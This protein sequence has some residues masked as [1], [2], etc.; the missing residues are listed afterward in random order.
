M[1]CLTGC[2][3]CCRKPDI[4]ATPLEFLPLA[5]ALWS[6]GKALAFYEE[7]TASKENTICTLF[8]PLHESSTGGMCR[9]YTSRG[10]ICR[11]FGFT[12]ARDRNGNAQLVTCRPIKTEQPE[13]YS[14]GLELT[15]KGH[16]AF[17]RDYY[18]RLSCIDP[19]LGRQML[20]VN[21][22]IRVALETVLSY[23]AYR[24]PRRT[25]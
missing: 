19:E 2:G 24:K 11:L 7:V 9:R 5:W 17:M 21:E 16:V 8:A 23:Y 14:S 1:H 25:A 13:A 12:A 6:E 22:A 15:A 18:F 3:L 4:T 10:L 20:P